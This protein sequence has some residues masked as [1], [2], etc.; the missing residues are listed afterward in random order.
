MSTAVLLRIASVISLVFT[1]G[2]SLGGLRK[3]SPMGDNS[4]L[5][6]MT[7][8]RFDTMGAN[9]SYLDFFMGFG[10]SLSVVMLMQTILL[11]QLASLARTDPARL[12]PMIAVIAL[13]T[14]ASGVIAWRFIFPVPALFSAVLALALGLAYVAAR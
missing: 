11:W 14:I 1:A 9:R 4:V 10:W 6:A 3:W 5:K 7:D 13:A 8:V 2:H 12:R